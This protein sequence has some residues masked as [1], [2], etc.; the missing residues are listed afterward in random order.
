MDTPPSSGVEL[1]A[2][3]LIA[4]ASTVVQLV[5]LVL[6]LMML[7]CW[8]IIGAKMVRL[9]Q[10]RKLSRAF[11]ELF[12]AEDE[13]RPWDNDS[14]K[15]IHAQLP[16]YT[17]SP[18]ATVFRAGYSELA[19]ISRKSTPDSGDVH[20]LERALRRAQNA[21]M[22]RLENL[23]PV[24]ATTGST[25]PFIGLF[26]TVWGIMS[27][28]VSIGHSHAAT[29]DVVAPGIA[30]ALIATAIGLAA[31]IPAVMA[32][33]YFVRRIKVVR[34]E[35]DAFSSDYLNIIQRHLLAE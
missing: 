1:N 8:F 35:V 2:L 14:M 10:A 30:E 31:A 34:H 4:Q 22:T 24:L 19:R 32:Y 29:L 5:L 26:G 7:A 3:D 17:G 25:A 28:F 16:T 15:D 20:N 11:L 21:E 33:N 6:F 9:N 18:L 27:A 23:I 12:W 13:T